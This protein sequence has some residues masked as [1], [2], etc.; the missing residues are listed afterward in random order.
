MKHDLFEL[1][2]YCFPQPLVRNRSFFGEQ[3]PT[4]VFIP[5]GGNLRHIISHIC[6]LLTIS[7]GFPIQNLPLLGGFIFQHDSISTFYFVHLLGCQRWIIYCWN[8]LPKNLNLFIYCILR[9]S[10][11]VG[12][13]FFKVIT[14]PPLTCGS[15]RLTILLKNRCKKAEQNK[16]GPLY[17][18]DEGSY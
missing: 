11:E 10:R 5:Y 18:Q 2:S 13:N 8:P 17:F 15:E 9:N 14:K 4:S 16:I 12:I 7:I 6:K 1:W 3:C